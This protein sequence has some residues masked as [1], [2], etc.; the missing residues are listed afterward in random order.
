MIFVIRWRP[1][2]SKRHKDAKLILF[3]KIINNLAQV[4]HEHILTKAYEGYGTRKKNDHNFRYIAV[5][6]SQ[7][8][9][10]FFPK[11]VSPWNQLSFADSPLW[12]IFGLICCRLIDPY[13]M[14]H[15]ELC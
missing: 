14:L 15:W 6:T 8:R 10:S 1:H 12:R 2:T 3:Y 7:Y 5:N 9:Q 11:T 13:V 4:P